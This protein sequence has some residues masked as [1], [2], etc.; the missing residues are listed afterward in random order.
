MRHVGARKLRMQLNC[1]EADS[2]SVRPTAPNV[3]DIRETLASI[4][5]DLAH[6]SM[7]FRAA[8]M[9]MVGPALN[10]NVDRLSARTGVPR[11]QAAVFTRR[12]FD[13]GV[14]QPEGPVY[15]WCS[16][17][18]PEFWN[19]V[20]VGEGKL[21]R[22]GG[23][24]DTIEWA[25][26]G[27]WRKSYDFVS[28]LDHVL[29]VAYVDET[30]QNSITLPTPL[31]VEEASNIIALKGDQVEAEDEGDLDVDDGDEEEWEAIEDEIAAKPVNSPMPSP[32]V[33]IGNAPPEPPQAVP[34]T[35]P[36]VW[37]GGDPGELF[38][39]AGWLI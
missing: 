18:E 35:P 24:I 20:A 34:V 12:W 23:R 14:W 31:V 21:C 26:P 36:H 27:V 10:F 28:K 30:A 22:R 29:S 2:R 16:P 5:P 8:I 6:D 32:T 15:P 4:R 17:N 3:Q 25:N 39:G 1:A 11:A 19:D 33:W 38:P 7:T 37:I 9:L 13:N